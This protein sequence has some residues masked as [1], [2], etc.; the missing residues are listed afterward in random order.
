MI[1]NNQE[2]NP[3]DAKEM[4]LDSPEVASAIQAINAF[5]NEN[6]PSCQDLLTEVRQQQLLI[7][8][9]SDYKYYILFCG[10]FQGKRNVVK[11]WPKY[12]QCFLTMVKENG[13]D[14]IKRLIQTIALYFV[15]FDKSQ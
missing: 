12:E 6:D 9:T 2:I 11:S 5:V 3:L 1:E 10:I 15:K 13:S 4:D 7:E 14:G 8:V